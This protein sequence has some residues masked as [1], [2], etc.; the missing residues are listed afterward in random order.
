MKTNIFPNEKTIF[1]NEIKIGTLENCTVKLELEI[2]EIT[3]KELTNNLQEINSY[4][5]VSISGNIGR[6][7]YGQIQ[8]TLENEIDNISFTEKTTKENL[9][10]ILDLW[11]AWHLNDLTAGSIKQE[12]CI[13]QYLKENNKQY[14]YELACLILRSNSLYNDNGY[15]YG[16]AWLV[17]IVP[18]NVIEKLIELFK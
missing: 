2:A 7:N 17:K 5:T 11:N 12:N 4:K 9:I 14:N 8:D 18:E 10:D 16:S 3:G 13:N 6:W 15:I 1:K